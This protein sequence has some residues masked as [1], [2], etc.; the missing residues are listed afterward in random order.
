MKSQ[1]SSTF[2]PLQLAVPNIS[3]SP[4]CRSNQSNEAICAVSPTK[5]GHH[6]SMKNLATLNRVMCAL[7]RMPS[8]EVKEHC[9]YI[10][11]PNKIHP[12]AHGH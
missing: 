11:H 7:E 6:G 8:T 12:T 10:T 4:I 1:I 5:K 2:I 3:C 9:C